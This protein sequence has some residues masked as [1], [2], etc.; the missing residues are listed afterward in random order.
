MSWKSWTNLFLTNKNHSLAI[1]D[2]NIYLSGGINH[3]SFIYTREIDGGDWELLD[4]FSAKTDLRF[5]DHRSVVVGNYLYL[6][7]GRAGQGKKDYFLRFELS[8]KEVQELNAMDNKR[9]RFGMEVYNNNIYVFGGEHKEKTY[10]EKYSISDDSWTRVM[11]LPRELGDVDSVRIEDNMWIMTEEGTLYKFNFENESVSQLETLTNNNDNVSLSKINK[12]LYYYRESTASDTG[13]FFARAVNSKDYEKKDFKEKISGINAPRGSRLISP[14]DKDHLFLIGGMTSQKFT[15]DLVFE[16]EPPQITE[17]LFV[18]FIGDESNNKIEANFAVPDQNDI[19]R[20]ELRFKTEE[21][22]SDRDKTKFLK[23]ENGNISDENISMEAELL[24][25]RHYFIHVFTM[26]GAGK[27]S[28][29]IINTQNVVTIHTPDNPIIKNIH[30]VDDDRV[31]EN[32][33]EIKLRFES[34]RELNTEESFVNFSNIDST[35][36]REDIELIQS[37]PRIYETTHVIDKNNRVPNGEYF[38][39]VRAI[40]K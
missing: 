16:P 12:N 32:R 27:F 30:Q 7:G 1:N 22:Q 9:Y 11:V 14:P 19:T 17:E 8:T 23:A 4:N 26:N 24:D 18:N 21:F 33:D 13:N 6:L 40:P 3:E 37:N 5:S 35:A 2:S 36:F 25:R 20:A 31:Y 39:T 29:E 10:I 34:N 15:G 28:E 38:V